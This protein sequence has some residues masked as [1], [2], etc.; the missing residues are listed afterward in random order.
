M[1]LHGLL[2]KTFGLAKLLPWQLSTIS[3]LLN[4]KDSLVI[5]PTGSGKSMCFSLPPLL[6]QKTALV[7]SPTISLMTDQ[8][9]KLSDRGIKATFLGTAQANKDVISKVANGDFSLVFTTPESFL[10]KSMNQPKE[11]F[12]QME[13]LRT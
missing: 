2:A 4:G 10:N 3:S 12:L 6:L 8:V 7:I 13:K 1:L 9:K 11:V 5:Q